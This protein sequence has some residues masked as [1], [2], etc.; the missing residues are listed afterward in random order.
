MEE[1]SISENMTIFTDI[2]RLFQGISG[3]K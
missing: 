1:T 3:E 2:I